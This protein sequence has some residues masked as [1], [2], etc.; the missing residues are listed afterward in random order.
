MERAV[1]L[2]SEIAEGEVLKG[3]EIYDK[4]DKENKK[5]EITVENIN[6]ILG[7]KLS[8]DETTAYISRHV[9]KCKSQNEV[10]NLQF[11]IENFSQDCKNPS[12]PEKS[13][14]N[15]FTCV[16]APRCRSDTG[17]F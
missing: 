4:A 14:G 7:T 9:I 13:S 2:L 12:F 5:I 8:K 3:T 17:R 11:Y 10:S 15:G 1:K 16:Q 6:N